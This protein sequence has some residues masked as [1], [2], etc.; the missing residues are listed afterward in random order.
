MQGAVH[1]MAAV[2]IL[3]VGDFVHAHSSWDAQNPISVGMLRKAPLAFVSGP[4]IWKKDD[5]IYSVRC[6]H[7]PVMALR[8]SGFLPIR[9][10]RMPILK[11]FSSKTTF[12]STPTVWTKRLLPSFRSRSSEQLGCKINGHSMTHTHTF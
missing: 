4:I 9:A 6:L 2:A 1:V 3:V 5:G 7:R 12:G 11:S 8:P 10:A